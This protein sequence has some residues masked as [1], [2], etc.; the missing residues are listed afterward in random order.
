[1]RAL[2]SLVGLRMLSLAA[3]ISE[4]DTPERRGF[5]SWFI[6]WPGLEV[7]TVPRVRMVRRRG[8]G[9]FMAE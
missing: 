6:T 5:D 9:S 1:M 4:G 2:V 8:R 3:A 7:A